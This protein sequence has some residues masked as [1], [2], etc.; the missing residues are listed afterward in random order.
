M[1]VVVE[2][3]TGLVQ[4]TEQGS[5]IGVTEVLRQDQKISR[6]LQR[7]LRDV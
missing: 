7:R 1:E 3:S 2:K 6:F 5:G 4:K